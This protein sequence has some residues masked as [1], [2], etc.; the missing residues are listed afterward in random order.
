MQRC[1]LL[2]AR[3][4]ELMR[5]CAEPKEEDGSRV[6]DAEEAKECWEGAL[7]N[8]GGE[9]REIAWYLG[10]LWVWAVGQPK[11]RYMFH[12]ACARCTGYMLTRS[13]G[14][15]RP[16]PA[17][18]VAAR[19]TASTM[20]PTVTGPRPRRLEPHCAR[21]GGVPEAGGGHFGPFPAEAAFKKVPFVAR[22]VRSGA[23]AARHEQEG[24][25]RGPVPVVGV[26][27]QPP[28]SLPWH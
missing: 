6:E 3:A 22:R 12:P 13:P 10:R 25:G 5:M 7:L 20:F 8:S 15:S 1:D 17:G 14:L 27:P 11:Y 4:N 26:G 16:N 18:V 23:M 9:R 28:L 2:L 21:R 24:P 19:M